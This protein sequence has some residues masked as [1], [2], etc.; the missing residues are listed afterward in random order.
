VYYRVISDIFD[1]FSYFSLFLSP[2][3]SLFDDRKNVQNS[4]IWN[5]DGIDNVGNLVRFVGGGGG[6][7]VVFVVV[8]FFH[9][10]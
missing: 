7:D 9:A 5:K 8:D 3:F 1:F 6:E 4:H 2:F 10:D